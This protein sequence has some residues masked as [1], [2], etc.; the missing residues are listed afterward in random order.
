[1]DQTSEQVSVDSFVIKR[2]ADTTFLSPC[3]NKK[4]ITAFFLE[5]NF[6]PFAMRA[7]SVYLQIHERD[8]NQRV[9][10]SLRVIQS[11][12]QQ[13]LHLAG[14]ASVQSTS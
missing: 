14:Q 2:I 7:P 5:N 1:M 11:P 10:A 12:H 4:L 13:Q 9:E 3:F 6:F 8:R